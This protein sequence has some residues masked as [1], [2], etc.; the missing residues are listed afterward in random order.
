MKKDTKIDYP[1]VASGLVIAAAF[2]GL[3][4]LIF[5]TQVQAQTQTCDKNCTPDDE[6]I[7]GPGET[8]TEFFHSNGIGRAIFMPESVA[9]GWRVKRVNLCSQGGPAWIVCFGVSGPVA[10]QII[11]PN[12]PGIVGEIEFTHSPS[13]DKKFITGFATARHVQDA[14]FRYQT[15]W[16]HPDLFSVPKSSPGHVVE[17]KYVCTNDPN[18]TF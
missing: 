2:I 14:Y 12:K 17:A 1:H 3:M 15:G 18:K 8:I 13:P 6:R 10:F 9:L 16:C 4:A 5:S 11:A 7:V